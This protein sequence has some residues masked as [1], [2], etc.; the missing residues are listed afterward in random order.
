MFC[1]R[2]VFY[3]KYIFHYFWLTIEKVVNDREA[4]LPGAVV[5][6]C[7]WRRG[8]K[9]PRPVWDPSRYLSAGIYDTTPVLHLG[10]DHRP[11]QN[12]IPVFLLILLFGGSCPIFF[13]LPNAK[14]FPIYQIRENVS[15]GLTYHWDLRKETRE[16]HWSSTGSNIFYGKHY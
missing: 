11:S 3:K 1:Y 12:R 8:S 13:E 2:L 14:L 16:Y 5:S 15:C 4:I 9:G 10:H 7:V 6:R